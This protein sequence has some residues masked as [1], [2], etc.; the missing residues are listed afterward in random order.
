MEGTNVLDLPQAAA[1]A[2]TREPDAEKAPG[3]PLDWK[4]QEVVLKGGRFRHVL[5]RPTVDQL[6]KRDAE[7]QSEIP[8]S[9]DGT[10]KLP[11]ATATEETDARIYDELVESTDGYKEIVPVQHKA[12]AFHG[13][14]IREI[15]VAEDCDIFGDEIRVVEETGRGFEADEKILH[16]FRQPTEE[17]LRRYRRRTNNGTLKPGKRGRQTFVSA[18]TLKTAIEHYDLWITSIYGVTVGGAGFSPDRKAVFV[19]AVDPLIKRQVVNEMVNELTGG[20]LD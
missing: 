11:D 16:T 15:Y 18:S 10:I 20:L 9:K 12:A 1:A 4:T 14:Y 17:E 2:V 8:L 13:M 6:I 19:D 7:L 5:R 3:F